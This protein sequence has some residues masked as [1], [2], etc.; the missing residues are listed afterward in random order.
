MIKGTTKVAPENRT[1][2]IAAALFLSTAFSTPIL[3]QGLPNPG[4]ISG[5]DQARAHQQEMSQRE[6]QLRNFGNEP[7]NATDPHQVKALIVQIEQ[8]FTRILILHN[9]MV[10]AISNDKIVDYSF[11]S[12]A[13]AEIRKRAARLQATLTLKKPEGSEQEKQI[14]FNDTQVKEALIT[15]CKQIKRFVTNP[16]IEN[17]GTVNVQQ[18][19]QARNDLESIIELSSSLKK[20]AERLNKIPK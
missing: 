14:E 18:L 13:T 1:T 11:I 7:A 5:G 6:W 17:P 10:R 4:T 3:A 19:T 9:Q 2:W 12:D 16:V 8:D 15:L 20:T